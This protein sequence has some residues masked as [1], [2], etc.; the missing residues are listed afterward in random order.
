MWSVPPRKATHQL[1]HHSWEKNGGGNDTP[2]LLF[3]FACLRLF[4]R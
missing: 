4:L 3:S 1:L 2:L